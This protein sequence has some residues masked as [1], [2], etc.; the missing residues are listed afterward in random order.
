MLPPFAGIFLRPMLLLTQR[1][2]YCP[3]PVLCCVIRR[4]AV[5]CCVVP[6]PANVGCAAL[7][8]HAVVCCSWVTGLE[9]PDA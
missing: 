2:L 5:V 9:G 4:P 7:L 6:H 3:R 1:C 8:C